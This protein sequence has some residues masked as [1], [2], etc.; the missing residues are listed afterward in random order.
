M[1]ENIFIALET[2]IQ[3]E[4]FLLIVAG[5]IL[6]II[7][8]AIPG[9]GPDIGIAIA[10]P[11]SFGYP[12]MQALPLLISIYSG[13]MFGGSIASIL[14]NTPG[15]GSAA[16]STLDGYPLAKKGEA[17]TALSISATSSTFGG[18]F[19]SILIISFVPYLHKF[20]L[21]FGTPEYC[22]LGFLGIVLISVVASKA[23]LKG[24]IVGSFCLMLTSIGMAPMGA[25]IRYTFGNLAL[26]DGIGFIPAIIGLFSVAE[27]LKLAGKKGKSISGNLEIK[28]SRLKGI[29]APFLH[30]STL[31]KSTIIGLLV[32]AVPGTGGTTASF[33]AYSEAMRS[34]KNPHSFGKGNYEG[35]ISTESSN[36]AVVGGALLPTL[37]FGIPGSGGMAVLLGGLLLHGLR[38]GFRMF[39]G[40]GVLITY[41]LILTNLIASI[42]IFIIGNSIS[43]FLGKITTLH[44]NFLIPLVLFL[45]V[46]SIYIL[47]HNFFD[48]VLV[49]FFGFLGYFLAKY[50][51]PII[52]AILG[53][54]LGTMIETNLNRSIQLGGGSLF[55]FFKR[56][57]SLLLISMIFFILLAPIILSKIKRVSSPKG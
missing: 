2:I 23:F 16:A 21:L 17:I 8:G 49:A 32:G 37:L 38:P 10:I 46:L 48:I 51:F 15:T 45:S 57:L 54:I 12:P 20:V 3:I 7:V 44:K 22:L 35:L 9:I 39:E 50:D 14:I 6:G 26:F 42:L 11:I 34:S 33:I 47:E 4:T 31:I 29:V 41:V 5:T 25:E 52:P 24:L 55:I 13:A 40:E 43:P 36:N 1:I 30:F 19:S 27:M 53:L 56:P 28:G 18:I